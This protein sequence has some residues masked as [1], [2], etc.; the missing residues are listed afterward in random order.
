MF[1]A[2]LSSLSWATRNSSQW[3]IAHVLYFFSPWT[4]AALTSLVTVVLISQKRL[5]TF[6]KPNYPKLSDLVRQISTTLQPFFFLVGLVII[7]SAVIASAGYALSHLFDQKLALPTSHAKAWHGLRLYWFFTSQHHIAQLIGIAIGYIFSG[8]ITM[9]IVPIVIRS[10]IGNKTQTLIESL[11][12]VSQFDP[13]NFIDTKKGLF[14]GVDTK[15]KPIFISWRKVSE[16]HMQIMGSTG[17]GKGVSLALM[18]KQLISKGKSLVIFDPKGDTHAKSILIE[19]AQK[20]Q[21]EFIFLDLNKSIPQI[22][23]FSNTTPEEASDLL[24]AAFELRSKG[25]D[26]DYYKGREED[27]CYI[28]SDQGANSLPTIIQNAHKDPVVCEEENFLRKL[29]KLER[30][31]V[32]MTQAGPDL[33]QAVQS[34]AVLYVQCSSGSEAVSMA[35]KLL[36][37]R[38]MQIIKAREDQQRSVAIILDEFKY[39]LS[40]AALTALGLMRS[41]NCHCLLAFQAIGDL[42]DNPMLNTESAKSAVLTNT[43]LKLIFR[44]PEISYAE[45]LSK[46]TLTHTRFDEVTGK[47]PDETNQQGSGSWR[48]V[49][50]PNIP[51]NLLTNLPMPT[52]HNDGKTTSCGVLFTGSNATPFV[53]CPVIHNNS[54]AGITPAASA[55]VEIKKGEDLI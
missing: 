42:L 32:F 17:S 39:M 6:E 20:E 11:T 5:G 40:P 10:G 53:T 26:G 54:Q 2:I 33:E 4:W 51:A 55:S 19:A 25:S 47:K 9:V 36:L 23:P 3:L 21:R 13:S 24:I 34:G 49:Q 43:A 29:R 30:S 8:F 15:R 27:C 18:G 31:K 41:S 45:E 48:E 44:I 22:N 50:E 7:T 52:D 38:I 14:I 16:T 12:K 37:L 28:L 35:Q 46:M 1:D